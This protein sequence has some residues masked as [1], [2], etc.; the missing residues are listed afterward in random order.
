MS[1]FNNQQTQKEAIEK[2]IEK[3]AEVQQRC[4]RAATELQQSCNRAELQ[5]SCNRPS[6][7]PWRV[8]WVEMIGT[9][10]VYSDLVCIVVCIACITCIRLREPG[11]CPHGICDTDLLRISGSLS[12]PK[13][14]VG[15]KKKRKDGLEAVEVQRF[16]H[17][18][19]SFRSCQIPHL[20][21]IK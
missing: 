5:Q 20:L 14:C 6:S 8:S 15:L 16:K 10:C 11:L 3:P 4:N 13:N 18:Y 12:F 1:D 2:Q 21:M 7:S 19:I 17:I 9:D